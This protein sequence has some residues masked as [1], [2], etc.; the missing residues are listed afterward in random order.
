MIRS[1][2]PFGDGLRAGALA[3]LLT[4]RPAG[5]YVPSIGHELGQPVRWP[6][7][8]V[9]LRVSD[10]Q[11]PPGLAAASVL[12][13]ARRAA[14]RWTDAAACAHVELRISGPT[15]VSRVDDDGVNVIAFRRTSWCRDGLK[16]S[17]QCYG[18]GEVART[19]RHDRVVDGSEFIAG[20]DIELDAV[21][22]E[23]QPGPPGSEQG[24]LGE[25]TPV[26]LDE[27]LVHEF[28]HV[29]GFEHPCRTGGTSSRATKDDRGRLLGPCMQDDPAL[30]TVMLAGFRPSDVSGLLGKEDVRALCT[31]YPRAVPR[32]AARRS[33]GCAVAAP[34]SGAGA[35]FCSVAAAVMI[36]LRPRRRRR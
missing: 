16:R 27:I 26:S 12:D 15:D 32:T 19:T 9:E 8:A 2:S 7:G 21:H 18:E 30:E 36:C 29:L 20:A 22:F 4:A 17:G 3:L 33:F 31:V 13:A 28:G 10:R 6:D 1:G 35:P 34:E 5:A 23:F 25:R 14:R 11:L 24:T